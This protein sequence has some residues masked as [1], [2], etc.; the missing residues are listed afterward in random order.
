[1]KYSFLNSENCLIFST[2]LLR[3]HFVL[4]K[5]SASFLKNFRREGNFVPLYVFGSVLLMLERAKLPVLFP[6]LGR[7][8]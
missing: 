4:P 2:L 8:T 5:S 6:C 3:F 1:M 7:G